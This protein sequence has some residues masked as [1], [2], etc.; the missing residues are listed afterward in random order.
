MPFQP[1]PPQEARFRTFLKNNRQR[2]IPSKCMNLGKFEIVSDRDAISKYLDDALWKE[3]VRIFE[4]YQKMSQ[5]ARG[6][7]LRYGNT[8]VK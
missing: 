6:K 8:L 1:F 3:L 2:L 7:F 4:L 5:R